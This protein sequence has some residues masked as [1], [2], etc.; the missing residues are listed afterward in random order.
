MICRTQNGKI[1][2]AEQTR[3]EVIADFKKWLEE[4][5]EQVQEYALDALPMEDLEDDWEG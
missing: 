2:M 3:E 1:G 5:R 4:H